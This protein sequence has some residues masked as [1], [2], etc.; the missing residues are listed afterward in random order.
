MSTAQLALVILTLCGGLKE[1]DVDFKC[2]DYYTNC[3]V[4]AGGTTA[5]VQACK[6]DYKKGMERLENRVKEFSND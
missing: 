2:V 3:A 6:D 5:A 4:D 1:K